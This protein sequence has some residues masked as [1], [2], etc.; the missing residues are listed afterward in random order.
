VNLGFVGELFRRASDALEADDPMEALAQA[1]EA[2]RFLAAY[3]RRWLPSLRTA[4]ATASRERGY[5][6]A[7]VELLDVLAAAIDIEVVRDVARTATLAVDNAYPLGSSRGVGEPNAEDLAEIA[8]RLRASGLTFDHVRARPQW[9]DDV[10]E[11][12]LTDD[13]PLASSVA[14]R[15]SGK[16]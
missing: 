2:R 15:Q 14:A 12:R 9:R 8:F 7:Y 4:C 16:D 5:P 13:G 3:P 1:A 11:R 6:G 10:F